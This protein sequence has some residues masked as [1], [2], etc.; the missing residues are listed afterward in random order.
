MGLDELR[1]QAPA[2]EPVKEG[3]FASLCSDDHE[4]WNNS[5]IMVENEGISRNS[6]LTGE[7]QA[8]RIGSVGRRGGSRR[9]SSYERMV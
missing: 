9:K 5:G 2:Q 8:F 7:I 4:T 3:D 1:C 6:G